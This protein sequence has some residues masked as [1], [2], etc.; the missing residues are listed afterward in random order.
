ML[1]PLPAI[2]VSSALVP[3]A[4]IAIPMIA[5][6]IVVLGLL[7][8][9][10]KGPPL[11]TQM[12]LALA[13]L[14]GGSVL[15]LAL[16]FVF[17]DPNGTTAWTWVLVA[18]NFMMMVPLGLWFIGL[19]VFQDR[20]I[21]TRG[22][23]WPLAFGAATTGSEALMGV[24]F[25]LGGANGALSAESTFAL[26]LSSVWFFWS[27]AGVMAALT[28]WARVPAAGRA[29]AAT[30][31]VAA[32]LA[33]WVTSHPAVGAVAMSGAMAAWFGYLGRLLRLRRVAPGEVGLV[34]GTSVA[35]LAMAS[36]GFLVVATAG[37]SWAAIVF[38]SAMG[39]T[40][41]AEVAYLVRSCYHEPAPRT[42]NA[43]AGEPAPIGAPPPVP[44]PSLEP[45]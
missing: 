32:V 11:L 43:G 35:F 28:F 25:A 21:L 19:V 1:L 3:Y 15:L 5:V 12:L 39:L 16:L 27:M 26:G 24:L 8:R 20:R 45:R 34:V 44:V 42:W 41:V 4:T 9:T 29:G 10:E 30:L 36:G 18:F 2:G 33:P 22:W 40:M 7:L 31:T 17:L 13:V 23:S 38:G 6:T 37:A 14:L